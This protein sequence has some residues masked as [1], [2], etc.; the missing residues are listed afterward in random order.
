MKKLLLC[1]IDALSS[2][3]LRPDIEA[4]KLPNLRKLIEAGEVD[5]ECTSIFP[6][7]TPA[8][9]AAIA[10]GCYPSE[11]GIIGAY[12][13]DR[14]QDRVHYYGNDLGVLMA[15]GIGRFFEDF[16][17]EMNLRRLQVDTIYEHVERAGRQA[18]CVNFLIYRGDKPHKVHV[19]LLLRFWPSIPF[20]AEVHGPTILSLGDFV[21]D[22]PLASERR[23]K[24]HGGV[25]HR[26]GFDD[27][28][29]AAVLLQMAQ[30][31]AL[32]DLTVAYFP[33]ND[34]ESHKVGP[35]DADTVLERF[36]RFVGELADTWGGI[37]AMLAELMIVLVGDHSQS[38]T[39]SLSDGVGIRLDELLSDYELVDPGTPWEG[40]DQLMI[41]PNLRAAQ[42]YL[43]QG[44]WSQRHEIIERV[45]HDERIDQ[46]IWQGDDHDR[47]RMRFHVATRDRGR[48]EFW[49]GDEG[50][51]TARDGYGMSWSW[52][53]DLRPVDGQVS[54]EGLITF[55]EYPNAFERIATGF[56][57]RMSGDI[58]VTAQ[59]GYEF[60][61][62][63][64]AVN[65]DGG[66]HATLARLDSTTT[67]LVAGG[68]SAFKI[69]PHVRTVDVM[70]ICLSLLGLET[71]RPVGASHLLYD[72]KG[73]R[74][75]WQ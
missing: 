41:C 10:T 53:G 68:D 16:L 48:L 49:P 46:V 51:H 19:P 26:F 8:A 43:R 11:H 42:L 25:F 36:D 62:S 55:F 12:F 47:N 44:V 35:K 17:L 60:I 56:E 63:R 67:L 21:N 5:W 1:V 20:S 34:F 59:L 15:E 4:G 73:Q 38:N 18:G 32:P 45:L 57:H 7:I 40:D 58:W 33:D 6:S 74:R 37:D 66:S 52:Q 14:E 39:V 71:P 27:S 69:P 13:Y 50:P 24:S 72:V 23:I 22:N 65:D 9:T 31:K 54:D 75:A 2:H 3:V 28:T 29:S 64:T 61:V 70:G 30:Q